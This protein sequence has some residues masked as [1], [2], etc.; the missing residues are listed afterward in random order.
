MKKCVLLFGLLFSINNLT[1]AQRDLDKQELLD[2]LRALT[3]RPRKTWIASGIIEAIREEY[4]APRITDPSE[5]AQKINQARQAYRENPALIEGTDELRRRAYNAIP[6]NVRYKYSNEC[7]MTSQV[8]VKYDGTRFYWEINVLARQDSVKPTP[9]MPMSRYFNLDWN[10][11]RVFVWDGEKYIIYLRPGNYALV[12]EGIID[13]PV[14]VNGPLTA[15]MVPWGCGIYQYDNLITAE[16]FAF[17]THTDNQKQIN[18]TLIY[19]DGLEMYFILDQDR[20]YAVKFYALNR[21]NL[22][23]T[24]QTYDDFHLVGGQWVPST[25]TMAHYEINDTSMK[26]LARDIW[27]LT[28]I[29]TD[30]PQ[31]DDFDVDYEIDALI[32]Y[33]S[34]LTESPLWYRYSNKVS[35]ANGVD[36]D[37]LFTDRLIAALAPEKLPQNCATLAVK[38]IAKQLGRTVV[39]Q[40]LTSLIDEPNNGTSLYAVRKFAQDLG[41][42]C[43]VIITDIK[44]LRYLRN[45]QVLLYIPHSNH[46]VVLGNIDDK[47]IRLIDLT[48]DDFFYRLELAKIKQAWKECTALIISNKTFKIPGPFRKINDDQLR[49][50]IGRNDCPFGCYTCTKLLQDY[51]VSF[52]P[53]PIGGICGGTYMEYFRRYGCESAPQGY[54]RGTGMLKAKESPCIN[55]PYDPGE[56][57]ITGEWICYYMR[58]CSSGN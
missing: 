6:F 20:D 12:K 18:L 9:A 45:C 2:V 5:I 32:E 46:Y 7:T 31:A 19:P 47:Y 35:A 11:K 8:I 13:V 34:P 24:W 50:I 25:I 28:S 4:K 38:Y 17:E 42:Y 16:M 23:T 55:D 1:F 40:E 10:A 29:K 56:C 44:T 15:G 30:R 53:P 37:A 26:L 41:L 33:Y 27:R 43:Q 49:K 36:T 22:L 21:P 3:A 48:G 54:C 51:Y 58:A 52:C 14:A 39:D 57:T